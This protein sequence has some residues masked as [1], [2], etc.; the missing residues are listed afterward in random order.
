MAP[1]FIVRSK[2]HHKS[3]EQLLPAEPA[4]VMAGVGQH[5]GMTANNP[6]STILIGVGQHPGMVGQHETE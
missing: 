1:L 5:A 4:P 3:P 2:R 6:G